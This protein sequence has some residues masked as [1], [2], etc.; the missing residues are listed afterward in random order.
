MNYFVKTALLSVIISVSGFAFAQTVSMSPELELIKQKG[1]YETLLNKLKEEFDKKSTQNHYD[2]VHAINLAW[3][4]F[5]NNNLTVSLA[6]ANK[7]EGRSRGASGEQGIYHS[8][9]LL[10]AKIFEGAGD[11]HSASSY[12]DILNLM[13]KADMNPD[14]RN[15]FLAFYGN[16]LK[17]QGNYSA[18][19]NL[20]LQA[21]FNSNESNDY[22]AILSLIYLN[23]LY[24]EMGL[25]PNAIKFIGLGENKIEA[26]S[27]TD[28]LFLKILNS[29]NQYALYKSKSET[30]INLDFNLLENQAMPLEFRWLAIKNYVKYFDETQQNE[31]FEKAYLSVEKYFVGNHP[32]KAQLLYH[33]ANNFYYNAEYKESLKNINSAEKIVKKHFSLEYP[34]YQ[35]L[36]ELKAINEWNLNE[37]D[38]AAKNFERSIYL[39]KVQYLKQFIFLSESEKELFYQNNKQSEIVY[40]Q[41][42]SDNHEKRPELLGNLLDHQ[43]M[44]KGLLFNAQKDFSENALKNPQNKDLYRKYITLK[45]QLI[46]VKKADDVIS[47]NISSLYDS[48]S[49]EVSL[50]EKKLSISNVLNSGLDLDKLSLTWDDIKY[51]LE[52]GEVLLNAIRS[53]EFDKATGQIDYSNYAYYILGIGRNSSQPGIL[54]LSAS[55]LDN[56]AWN[57]YK[58][59]IQ[60]QLEDTLS[61]GA[62]WGEIESVFRLKNSGKVYFV[63]D[64]IY[65]L[66]NVSSLFN[67]NSGQFVFEYLTL[68]IIGNP[69]DILKESLQIDKSRKNAILFGYPDFG[70]NPVAENPAQVVQTFDFITSRTRG[71]TGIISELPGTRQEVIDINGLIDGKNMKSEILLGKRASETN[72]KDKLTYSTFSPSIIHVATHGFFSEDKNESDPLSLSG[73]LLT[74]AQYAFST[75][76]IEKQ[77]QGIHDG[78]VVEDGILLSREAMYLNLF[79][80]EIVILSACETGQGVNNDGEGV[81]GL[82]RAFQTAGAQAV[83]MSLWKV[84]DEATKYFMTK[85]YEEYFQ[86]SDKDTSIKYARQQTKQKYPHPY[87]WGAFV[88]VGL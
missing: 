30:T 81:Y 45:E 14:F 4:Y 31:N 16:F 8:T 74:G 25:L 65:N 22:L 56:R 55:N 3:A 47:G 35:K 23:D 20:L 41:F 34:G 68:D 38:K 26:N 71:F 73:I 60:F 5:Y 12:F 70:D 72:F 2:P 79:T 36:L 29:Q 50:I 84:D 28:P 44:F 42:V 24:L 82:H 62:F 18:A 19:E 85:F 40:T 80:T 11:I 48:L 21:W 83:I 78:V 67:P 51:N 86:S 43:I 33:R 6:I 49:S 87:Y 64:G 7:L 1:E 76:L 37:V 32:V 13:E 61:F 27:T 54:K 15:Y 39:Q 17:I 77:M 63:P 9:L 57:F 75:P 69:S 53:P 52:R 10:K 46:T 58:N 88:K 59:T 66:I